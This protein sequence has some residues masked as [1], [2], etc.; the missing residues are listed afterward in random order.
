MNSAALRSVMSAMSSDLEYRIM[1][2]TINYPLIKDFSKL[3]PRTTKTT[4][5][6]CF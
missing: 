6:S 2:L 4:L 5:K 3:Y 1:E